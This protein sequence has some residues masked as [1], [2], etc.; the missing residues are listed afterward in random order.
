MRKTILFLVYL[1]IPA[2]ANGDVTDLGNWYEVADP[3]HP[4]FAASQTSVT[5]ILTAADIEIPASTDIGYQSVNGPTP[6]GSTSGFYFD[7][8]SDFS[9]AIDYSL[10]FSGTPEGLLGLGFGIGEHLDGSNSAGVAMATVD[11]NPSG[12]FTAASRI[13]DV[14]QFPPPPINVPASLSGSLFIEYVASSG[15]VIVGASTS[16]AATPAETVTLSG[17][18]NQWTDDK[19]LASFFLRSDSVPFGPSNWKGGQ[20]T[21]MF[22]NFRV[23]SGDP[24]AIPEP[25][26]ATLFLAV[27]SFAGLRRKRR[28]RRRIGSA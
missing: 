22:T 11:G 16:A 25:G 4:G 7:P 6:D 12:T 15:D 1:M 24:V 28:A 17:I 26:P 2:F 3:P 13:N 19:L 14:T 23:L 20:A 10:S 8:V 21:A 9:I 5:A 18:Q 27:A